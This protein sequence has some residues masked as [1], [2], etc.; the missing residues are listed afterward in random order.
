MA[1]SST[2]V[3]GFFYRRSLAGVD[4]P[5][6]LEFIIEDSN[7]ITLGDAVRLQTTGFL[8]N[9]AAGEPVLGIVAGLVDRGGINVFSP[10]ANSSSVLGTTLTPDDTI[11]VSSTNSSDAT[12]EVKAQVFLD[13]SGDILWYNDADGNLAQTNVMQLFDVVAA[14]DQ[15]DQGSASDSNGQFQLLQIDPDDDADLS[16]GLFRIVEG[17]LAVGI[18]QGTAIVTA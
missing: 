10:R 4:G 5:V 16:K 17:Q 7:T 18:D 3:A 9:S 14:G 2:S 12:R 1:A 11:T 8:T 15:I 13:T 6:P